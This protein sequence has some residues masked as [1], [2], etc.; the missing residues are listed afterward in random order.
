MLLSKIAEAEAA[1]RDAEASARRAV[2][3]AARERKV[4][5]AATLAV[6]QAEKRRIAEAEAAKRAAE[7]AQRAAEDEQRKKT[8]ICMAAV[9][10]SIILI[11]IWTLFLIRSK[12]NKRF[13]SNLTTSRRG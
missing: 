7:D 2:E 12:K 4:A 6:E 9:A 13:A 1:K 5:E 10:L 3:E 11:S 8:I